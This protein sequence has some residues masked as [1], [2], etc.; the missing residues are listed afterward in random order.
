MFFFFYHGLIRYCHTKLIKISE[1]HIHVSYAFRERYRY[2][3]LHTIIKIQHAV[4]P[5]YVYESLKVDD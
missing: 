3:D 2:D 4:Y 1:Q 5:L